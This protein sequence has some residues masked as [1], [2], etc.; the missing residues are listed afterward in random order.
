MRNLKLTLSYDG[1]HFQ[2]WQIQPGFRTV[3]EVVEQAIQSIIQERV[4]SNVCGRTDAGVHALGQVVN[5]YTSTR[6]DAKTL[7]KA[8]NAKLP[9]DVAV[10]N[11]E[12][13]GQSFCANKDAVTKRYRYVFYDQRIANPFLRY[14]AWHTKGSLDA[15]A[16]NRAVQAIRGRFDFRSFQSD[17]PNRMSSIRTITDISVVHQG[18]TVV[19][20]VEADGF[21]YNMV[22]T[23]AGT[24]FKVGRGD[25]PETMVGD[26]QKAMDRKV[27]GPTAPAH[28]LV[29][30]R[31]NYNK[32]NIVS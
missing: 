20:E 22:R 17:F 14:Y 28:G 27:A 1:T 16:M 10:L 2:G 32:E 11:V 6:L 4:R 15:D 29:M 30:V 7:L 26:V 24:A 21:L 9:E 12:D 13:V 5:F 25:W 8:F 18:D 23:I 31:V 3:Q 19:L